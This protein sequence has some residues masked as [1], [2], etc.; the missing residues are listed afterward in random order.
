MSDGIKHSRAER[1]SIEREEKEKR[2]EETGNKK[3]K[4]IIIEKLVYIEIVER[5]VANHLDKA[6]IHGSGSP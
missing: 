4:T 6:W 1:R 2:T 3:R 5:D